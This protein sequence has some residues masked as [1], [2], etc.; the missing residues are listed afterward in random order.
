MGYWVAM[1]VGLVVVWLGALGWML[2]GTREVKNRVDCNTESVIC[3]LPM[4]G[5][6]RSMDMLTLTPYG[7]CMKVCVHADGSHL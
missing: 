3:V 6:G 2:K 1:A 7:A 5:I 4:L